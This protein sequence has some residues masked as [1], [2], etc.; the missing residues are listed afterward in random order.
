MS[1]VFQLQKPVEGVKGLVQE[2]V[3]RVGR[4]EGS[5]LLAGL[6]CVCQLTC[7]CPPTIHGNQ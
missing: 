7:Y 2:A 3:L 1:A 5:V 4:L 6:L